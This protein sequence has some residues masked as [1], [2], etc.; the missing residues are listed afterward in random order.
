MKNY[1]NYL[2]FHYVSFLSL[3]LVT[4]YKQLTMTIYCARFHNILRIIM[5]SDI[6]LFPSSSSAVHNIKPQTHQHNHNP[7]NTRL[8]IAHVSSHKYH[9][10][11]R[12][13]HLYLHE[14]SIGERKITMISHYSVID[15]EWLAFRFTFSF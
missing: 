1:C 8:N 3:S 7:S 10:I 6:L 14:I 2:L 15:T 11:K 13:Y 4:R 9:S 12:T 5:I